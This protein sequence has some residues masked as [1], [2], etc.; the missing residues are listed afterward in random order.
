MF[1]ANGGPQGQAR[2]RRGARL[3]DSNG[4]APQA[5]PPSR[6]AR[7]VRGSMGR[8]G[9]IRDRAKRVS[10]WLEAP[11]R[12]ALGAPR[13]SQIPASTV[14]RPTI[15]PGW[16]LKREGS[17]R[18]SRD[19]GGFFVALKSGWQPAGSAACLMHF[20]RSPLLEG[21]KKMVERA[22]GVG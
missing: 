16:E 5:E 7:S 3:A 19:L 4:Q 12:D 20:K 15:S 6:G 22:L 1:S 17:S 11:K 8:E 13:R 14:G 10:K 18:T 9:Q 21:E 2:R